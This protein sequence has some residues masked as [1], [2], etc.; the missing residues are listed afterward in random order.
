MVFA[1]KHMERSEALEN[2]ARTSLEEIFSK[3][4]QTPT[5]CHVTFSTNKK[6]QSIHI[7]AHLNDGHIIELEHGDDDLY[8]SVDLIADKLSRDLNK[9][10]NKLLAKRH[11][12]VPE[13]KS[14]ESE[15]D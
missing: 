3:F 9:H 8:K 6:F 15:E 2:A 12:A 13:A 1:F 7:S 4:E 11:K 14:D 5:S 10:K